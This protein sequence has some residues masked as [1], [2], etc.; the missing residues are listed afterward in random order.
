MVLGY[1]AFGNRQMFY[2]EVAP[3]VAAHSAG[4]D[5]HHEP[6]D[7]RKGLDH[8]ALFLIF[9]PIFMFADQ[10]IGKM[11]KFFYRIKIFKLSDQLSKY[12]DG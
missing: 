4:A 12:F 6:L 9:A 10:I 8:T 7:Y 3:I 1:W 5:P 11:H 2:N